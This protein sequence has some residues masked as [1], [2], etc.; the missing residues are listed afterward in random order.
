LVRFVSFRLFLAAIARARRALRSVDVDE[1]VTH[2]RLVV[3]N[4]REDRLLVKQPRRAC[5]RD[6]TISSSV[7]LGTALPRWQTLVRLSCRRAH[8]PPMHV[9]RTLAVHR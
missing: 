4:G 7:V 6:S 9:G 1:T 8:G 5:R 3:V 2:H